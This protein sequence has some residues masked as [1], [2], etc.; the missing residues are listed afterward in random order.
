MQKLGLNQSLQQKLSP[1]QIQ[2]IKLLQIPVAELE[3]RVEEELEINPA[4]EEGEDTDKS[5][6]NDNA[7]GDDSFDNEYSDEYS[8]NDDLEIGNYLQD[9]SGYKMYGDGARD[10]DEKDIPYASEEGLNEALLQ[11]L[12]FLRMNDFE[13]LLGEQL[14]G[15]LDDDGYLRR[16]IES[17]VNDLAFTKGI[18]TS[19]E[20]LEAILKK[21][22]QFDPAGIGARDLQECLLL[23]LDRKN[24]HDQ[25]VHLAIKVVDDYFEELSK[26]HYEKI[27]KKLNIDN[28]QLKAIIKII[29]KLNPKPGSSDNNGINQYLIPDFI[30]TN[31][32][33]KF[34]L[35][36]NSKNAPEL[37]ISNSFA[38]MLD[39]Y[40][41]S[42]KQNK[43]I[44]ET[45][46]FIKQKL[47]SAKW[48]I[49]AIKQ[50][51]NTLLRTMDAIVK[52]QF[53]F[54]IDGDE[55]KLKPMIL[56]N[57]ADMIDMD[58][59]TISR[60]ANGKSVQTEFGI[61]QLKHF[62]SEGIA[63]DSGEDAS[64]REVKNILKEMTENE[65]KSSPLSDDKLEK[66]L[67]ERG[68]NI[69]RRTVAKYREQMG[70]PVARLRKEL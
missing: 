25:N 13:H 26:R 40:H 59:S 53:E 42:D 10:E 30:L 58:I 45:V 57:I 15:S 16:N 29:T 39:T 61:Y 50:R 17:I 21:I 12:G 37:R 20:E 66:I 24:V 56:K 23:Q 2:F 69:A 55:N 54:F 7:D 5:E 63:T 52:F 48:F 31:I 35:T 8:N 11:Q 32:G 60:V 36:L 64:S 28:E 62:F 41:K 67:N 43:S 6:N 70:I 19:T 44:K 4:L 3:A 47:D 18:E 68:Y 33:G 49:D 9:E 51:Q 38:E 46:T 27:Q 1:Q 34:E 14:I 22:Q 65:S